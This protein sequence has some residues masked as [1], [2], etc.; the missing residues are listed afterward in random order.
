MVAIAVLYALLTVA[1]WAASF[2]F[3]FWLAKTLAAKKERA[4][5]MRGY[6]VR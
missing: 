4:Q 2:G 5:R 3:V 1:P 6:R